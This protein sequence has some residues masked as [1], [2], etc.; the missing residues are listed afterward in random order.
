VA[1]AAAARRRT[2]PQNEGNVWFGRRIIS[3]NEHSRI[4][5]PQIRRRN[6]ARRWSTGSHEVRREV[7][8]W[9]KKEEEVVVVVVDFRKRALG[10]V[11]PGLTFQAGWLPG[12]K[13]RP[14]A[15]KKDFPSR[16]WNGTSPGPLYGVV[17]VL[18]ECALQVL[19]AARRKVG[20]WRYLQPEARHFYSAM[21]GDSQSGFKLARGPVLSSC[22]IPAISVC[23]EINGPS[24]D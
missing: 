21:S 10:R 8:C 7:L 11:L 15:A 6:K 24:S 2:Q 3:S 18:V 12:E 19:S 14:R 16:Q 13:G 23:I 17:R 20:R 4:V 5:R 1:R 22:I 9:S